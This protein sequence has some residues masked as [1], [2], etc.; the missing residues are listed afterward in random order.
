MGSLSDKEQALAMAALKK[1]KHLREGA[2]EAEE[3]RKVDPKPEVKIVEEVVAEASPATAERIASKRA[4]IERKAAEKAEREAITDLM[5]LKVKRPYFACHQH[6]GGIKCEEAGVVFKRRLMSK[7]EMIARLDGSYEEPDETKIPPGMEKLYSIPKVEVTVDGSEDLTAIDLL[8]TLDSAKLVLKRKNISY[9]EVK[10]WVEQDSQG[11][12]IVMNLFP[13]AEDTIHPVRKDFSDAETWNSLI[14]NDGLR[15][16][17]YQI[18]PP[19]RGDGEAPLID[20]SK[21][22]AVVENTRKQVVWVAQSEAIKLLSNEIPITQPVMNPDLVKKRK[23]L[24]AMMEEMGL[25]QYDG[26][27]GMCY[28]DDEATL[29]EINENLTSETD[30]YSV[31]PDHLDAED[32]RAYWRDLSTTL[33]EFPR[34]SNDLRDKIRHLVWIAIEAGIEAEKHRVTEKHGDALRQARVI[35]DNKIKPGVPRKDHTEVL[36]DAV[37]EYHESNPDVIRIT[38]KPVRDFIY[39]SGNEAYV[40]AYEATKIDTRSSARV[41]VLNHVIREWR[42]RP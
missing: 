18:P 19:P 15:D 41:D 21:W 40:E 4:G 22:K 11:R 28:L 5:I 3:P 17:V 24:D 31:N 12:D 29:E 38:E 2:M 8:P 14:Y 16:A 27:N 39:K 33:Q 42:K 36:F 30:T 23:L 7:D 1:K 32:P 25:L 37:Q 34:E 35:E 10:L 6:Q 26:Q 9:K 13:R 20:D